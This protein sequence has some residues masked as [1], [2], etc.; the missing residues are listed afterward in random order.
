[1]A[2]IALT[3]ASGAPGVTTT[4]VGLALLWPRPVLLIDADPSGS[5]AIPAGYFRGA[6][7]YDGGLIELAYS[8]AEVADSLP[9]VIRPIA[10]S[11]ASLVAGVRTPSQAGALRDLWDPL[12]NAL[13]GLDEAGQ[14]VIVDAGRLSLQGTPGP[15]LASADVTVLLSR[16]SLPALA[17]AKTHAE[18]IQKTGGWRCPA[19]ILVGEGQ[20]YRA[21]EVS[22][23]LG[24]PVLSTIADD[25]TSAAVFTYGQPPGRGFDGSKLIRTL[26]ATI[27]SLQA[28]VARN[29][30][31]LL[32]GTVR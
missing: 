22:R 31:A 8:P 28:Q 32:A 20:P 12:S 2:V 6:R 17:A 19:I 24:L 25:P 5:S 18:A 13:A 29:N 27:S 3:S 1:M 15:V 7:E 23:V 30:A 9:D 11:H 14:D 26:R 4:A 10:G 21:H 16:S